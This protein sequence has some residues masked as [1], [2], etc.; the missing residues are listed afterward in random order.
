M[1]TMSFY[2][3]NMVRRYERQLTI[4]KKLA[5]YRNALRLAYEKTYTFPNAVERSKLVER[6]AREMFDK[7]L[8][9]GDDTAMVRDVQKQLINDFGGNIAF[10][11]LPEYAEVVILQHEDNEWKE[12]A[13]KLRA[14]ILG[15]AWMMILNKVN[16]T[17]L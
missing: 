5:R 12:V 1:E 15:H 13:P 7:F 11:Y 4:A 2:V 8:L 16:E 10:Q 6:V 3:Q 17:M 9:M 14:N